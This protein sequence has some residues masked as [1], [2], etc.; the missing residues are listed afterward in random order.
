MAKSNA[1]YKIEDPETLKA[2]D[3]FFDKRAQ[4]FEAIS[5]MCEHYGYEN[6][7]V[8]ET[9]QNGIKF[10][11]LLADPKTDTVDTTKWKT[12]KHR[13]GYLNIMPRATAKEHKAEYM[14]MVPKSMSY[15]E[16]SKLILKDDVSPWSSGFGYA[17]KKGGHFIFET[18]IEVSPVAIEILASEYK[19]IN[20]AANEKD[21][22]DE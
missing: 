6:Y 9:I 22:T 16:L 3:V 13:N 20:I 18:S 15:L 19:K 21:T 12:S 17:Y 5:K 2:I 7:T 10:Y 14:A 8:H 11:N 4:F 1:Y